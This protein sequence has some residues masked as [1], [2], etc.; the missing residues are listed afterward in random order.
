M[1]NKTPDYLRMQQPISDC[2]ALS[3]NSD[4]C[5]LSPKHTRSSE[6]N[7]HPLPPLPT[8][9][10][11]D[12]WS[13]KLSI[14]EVEQMWQQKT[15][16]VRRKEYGYT[17]C[18]HMVPI[19]P[20]DHTPLS[21]KYSKPLSR[22]KI[23][24]HPR[25]LATYPQSPIQTP[26]CAAAPK[27]RNQ[28]P[29]YADSDTMSSVGPQDSIHTHRHALPRIK[30]LFNHVSTAHERP[31]IPP[32]HTTPYRSYGM[33]TH[34]MAGVSSDIPTPSDPTVFSNMRG[35]RHKVQ[36]PLWDFVTSIEVQQSECTEICA[37]IQPT[38]NCT[39]ENHMNSGNLPFIQQL[40]HSKIVP[41]NNVMQKR[42]EVE[43]FT[44]GILDVYPDMTFDGTAGKG[45]RE[46][47]FCC[48]IM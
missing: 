32:P 28:P 15:T 27:Q 20:H 38:R 47:C 13:Q 46:C 31:P 44:K 14:E 8:E 29:P 34:E 30:P 39:L 43:G 12:K 5:K 48:V 22:T 40:R 21:S 45:G 25:S 6:M 41:K 2:T 33:G 16:T 26:R 11:S 3:Q 42:R 37:G 18:E 24:E 10:S 1:Y 23:P 4:H 19:I 9:E 35:T 36:A 7:S 17:S